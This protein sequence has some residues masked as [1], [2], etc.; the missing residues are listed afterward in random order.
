MEMPTKRLRPIRYGCRLISC[1]ESRLSRVYRGR[2]VKL[3]HEHL[4]RDHGFRWGYTSVKTQLH[5]AAWWSA[6]GRV[7]LEGYRS[8]NR[9][10]AGTL[11]APRSGWRALS[12]RKAR[13]ARLR[14]A[15]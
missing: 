1:C 2:N 7:R 15:G 12:E 3:F 11:T 4:V 5:T 14:I 9:I 6:P 8:G 13:L 10:E